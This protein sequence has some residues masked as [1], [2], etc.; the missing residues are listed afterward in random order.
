MSF[1]CRYFEFEANSGVFLENGERK[2]RNA[3]DYNYVRNV[4]NTTDASV[5]DIMDKRKRDHEYAEV[6]NT[7]SLVYPKP[8]IPGIDGKGASPMDKRRVFAKALGYAAPYDLVDIMIARQS[9]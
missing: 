9:L 5:I 4:A 8:Y 3:N 7:K 1:A 6:A 2:A